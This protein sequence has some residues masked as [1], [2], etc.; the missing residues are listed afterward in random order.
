MS[1]FVTPPLFFGTC[2]LLDQCR[3]LLC[4][5]RHQ[6]TKRFVRLCP[7]LVEVVTSR[8]VFIPLRRCCLFIGGCPLCP[9]DNDTRGR[10]GISFGDIVGMA[11][12]LEVVD[13]FFLMVYPF[14][15]AEGSI[16]TSIQ[17]LWA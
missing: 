14:L 11:M 8:G 5:T 12:V 1:G 13:F 3:N 6:T 7:F 16:L 9:V 2:Q 10:L 4:S 17:F 15:D